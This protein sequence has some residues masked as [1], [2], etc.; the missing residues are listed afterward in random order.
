MGYLTLSTEQF[1]GNPART[2]RHGLVLT[3]LALLTVGLGGCVTSTTGLQAV[4]PGV[5]TGSSSSIADIVEPISA[6]AVLTAD[7]TPTPT[8]DPDEKTYVTVSTGGARANLRSGPNTSFAILAKGNAGESFEVASKTEAGDWFEVVLN[9]RNNPANPGDTA[10][11]S[12]DIVT[13][14][15]SAPVPISASDALLT[16]D[17]AAEW[18]VDWTCSSERC[19]LKECTADVTAIVN[20][21]ANGGYLPVEHTVTWADEC[22]NTDAWTFDV[23]QLT[24]EERTGEADTNFLYSYWLGAQPGEANGVYPLGET[25]GVVVYCSGPHEVTLE[26]GGGWTTVYEGNTCHD[27]NTGMLVY[28]AY[29]KRWFFTGEFEGKTYDKA[30]FGDSE[31]LEQKLVETTALVDLV[32]KK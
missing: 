7:P 6:Y 14:G 25:E 12:A 16:Q 23:N 15:G 5:T 20:R 17:L 30:Y 28:M 8:P 29:T 1:A 27:V 32:E 10:W 21:E 2:F 11:V 9:P 24:G 26:E 3:L 18:S 22:F 19:P 13:V 4:A 31:K